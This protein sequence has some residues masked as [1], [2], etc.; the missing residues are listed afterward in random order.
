[1]TNYKVGNIFVL[2][3]IKHGKEFQSYAF[4]YKMKCRIT[5]QYP[6]KYSRMTNQNTL[7]NSEPCEFVTKCQVYVTLFHKSLPK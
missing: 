5:G 7:I 3:G 1:M 4:N 2:K 6:D